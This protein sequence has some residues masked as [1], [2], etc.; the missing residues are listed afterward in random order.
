MRESCLAAV[1]AA[2]EAE[3]TG[4]TG[5][6]QRSFIKD[7]QALRLQS[8]SIVHG[9]QMAEAAGARARSQ[10]VTNCW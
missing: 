7:A 5:I 6:R 2:L 10:G 4:A 8:T 1:L 9:M 3:E